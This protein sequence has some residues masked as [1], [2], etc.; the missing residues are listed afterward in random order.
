VT[1]FD[2]PGQIKVMLVLLKIKSKG[3]ASMPFL[4]RPGQ[5]RYKLMMGRPQ[6]WSGLACDVLRIPVPVP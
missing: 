2:L 4:T 6:E 1:V 3:T 5:V